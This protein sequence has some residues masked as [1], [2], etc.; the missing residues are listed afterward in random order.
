[1]D[2]T[3]SEYGFSRL[4]LDIL[5]WRILYVVSKIAYLARTVKKLIETN[6]KEMQF[7]E[8]HIDNAMHGG[9]TRATVRDMT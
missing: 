7:T 6:G 1:M 5:L 9:S 3:D 4:L 2:L 8:R